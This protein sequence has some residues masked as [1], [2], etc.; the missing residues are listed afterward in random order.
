M[1]LNSLLHRFECIIKVYLFCHVAPRWIFQVKCSHKPINPY[2]WKASD[3]VF[4]YF[5]S[6]LISPELQQE[7]VFWKGAMW[8]GGR[9]IDT[10]QSSGFKSYR[11][12]P[13]VVPMALQLSFLH[14]CVCQWVPILQVTLLCKW[15]IC[16][17]P[18]WQ[19]MHYFIT[20]VVIRIIILW[21]RDSYESYLSKDSTFLFFLT[22]WW[23]PFISSGVGIIISD[24][25]P[26]LN[27]VP[28]VPP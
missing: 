8:S 27:P 10:M 7:G 13:R 22:T 6:D 17:S 25:F 16:F 23:Q 3:I 9:S 15:F 5:Y 24:N 21:R 20:T 12:L 4:K 2:T 18:G 1:T 26:K 11:G 28:K 19:S 14:Q